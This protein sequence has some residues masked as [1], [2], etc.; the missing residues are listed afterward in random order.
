MKS[1]NLPLVLLPL[2][3]AGAVAFFYFSNS[4]RQHAPKT[5]EDTERADIAK[6]AVDQQLEKFTLAGFDDQGDSNW[7]L[8]GETAKIDPGQTVYLDENVTLRL[9]DNTIIRTDKVRWS[10]GGGTLDT[11]S[12]VTVEHQNATIRGKGAYGR[13]NEGFIQ[14]NREIEMVINQSTRLTCLGPMKIWYNQNM[15]TF[16]RKVKV[17]DVKGVLSAN[18]MDV[19]FDPESKKVKEIIALGGV[20]IEK[21]ED[22]SRSKKAI[23]SVDTGSVRLEGSPEITLRQQ[24]GG[25]ID[26][27]LRNQAA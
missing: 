25:L 4:R 11:D 15:M 12:I 27:A 1:K 6:A 19:T 16:Y 24:S 13:P 14:L 26:G 18:R 17:F 10:Q 23:Y 20:V 22:V 9:R 7:K 21:G 8:E 5:Q 3:I 2:V